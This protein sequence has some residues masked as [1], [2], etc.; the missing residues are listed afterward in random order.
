M[1]AVKEA[2]PADLFALPPEPMAEEP[3][4]PPTAALPP[5]PAY[6]P[7][8]TDW[9]G[10]VP[11]SWDVRRL[12]HVAD[13]RTSN[14]DKKSVEGEVP[15]RLCNYTDVYYRDRITDDPDFMQATATA[16]QV[17][18]FT[19]QRGDVMIT[20][21]S[22]DPNDIAVPAVVA[23]DLSG[24]LCG[25][26]L[27][28]IR[29]HSRRAFGDYLCRAF[30]SHGVR[31]QFRTG[32]SGVTRF[33]LSGHV[34][35]DALFPLPPLAEQRGIAGFLDRATGR[36]DALVA[37]KRRLLDLLAE[38]RQ[39]LITHAVT[40][41]LDPR[42]PTRPTP[43]DWLGDVPEHWEVRPVKWLA[44]IRQGQVDPR[45]EPF[46][47]M[48][49]IG[50]DH[51]ES[52]TGRLLAAETAA[53]QGAI[54]GKYLFQPGDVLYSKIRPELCKAVE[55]DS[56]G[57]CSADIYAMVPRPDVMA[58]FLTYL[59]LSD[60]FTKLAVDESM[61][62]AM[63]KVNRRTLGGIPLPLP[64]SDEQSQIIAHLDAATARLDGLSAK[65]A[66]AIDRLAEYRAALITAA[67]TGRVDVRATDAGEVA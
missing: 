11:E 49:L 31:D 63:P 17:D 48:R 50:P 44:D 23:E 33:G 3:D 15:V 36:V 38:R 53:E 20:K 45:E 46:S 6:K 42:A 25:Y 39:A 28:H 52:G 66:A 35:A 62:V 4:A 2:R 27:T 51:I 57:L 24:V 10:D 1:K 67:V 60:V 54:S 34:I 43:V 13:L 26:H 18:R 22:E 9:L 21:D 56:D 41:G 8:G 14:V 58:T 7:S 30:E 12:K 47:S 37:K 32:A 5:Y 59:L 16:D 65:V 40:R 55:V 61:R 29:P 64:P 19:L